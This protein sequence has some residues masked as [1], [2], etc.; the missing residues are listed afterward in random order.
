M[1]AGRVTPRLALFA[2]GSLVSPE[3]ASATL[4]RVPSRRAPARLPG[5]RRRWSQA[6]DNVAVEKTFARR[7]DGAVPRHVLGLNLEPSNVDAVGPNGVLLE[8]SEDEL[9]RLDVREMRYDRIEVDAVEGFDRVFTY[10]AKR[11]NRASEPPEG[12][13]VIEAYV[14]RVERAF[15]A[16][17]DDQLR[18]YRETTDPPPVEVIDA[19]LVRDRIPPGNPR[20]W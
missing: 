16:L 11:A 5:W 17:G 14:Q 15:A 4:G 20:E 3:S 10:T 8:L 6:R 13:V 9:R 1:S 19:V 2:Y 7:S 18:L 12:A